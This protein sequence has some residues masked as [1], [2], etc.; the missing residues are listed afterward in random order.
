M[1]LPVGTRLYEAGLQNDN[2]GQ[3]LAVANADTSAVLLNNT[4]VQGLVNL[5]THAFSGY[6]LKVGTD[7]PAAT[8]SNFVANDN[9]GSL[10]ALLNADTSATKLNNTKV[11]GLAN[12]GANVFSAYP[13]VVGVDLPSANESRYVANDGT[14]NLMTIL[15]N[16]TSTVLLAN[17]K[18]TGLV[19]MGASAFSA[20]PLVVGTDMPRANESHFVA[21][22]NTGGLM[23]ILNADTSATKLNS[24]KLGGPLLD[25]LVAGT[26]VTITG[27]PGS[28]TGSPTISATGTSH[29]VASADAY[30]LTTTT[31]TAVMSY[32][33]PA[34]GQ[35]DVEVSVEVATAATIVTLVLS[36]YD[37]TAGA[38][39]TYDL[40]PSGGV[41]LAPGTWLFPLFG[42]LWAGTT[43]AI[44]V[45]ATAST[46]NQVYVSGRIKQAI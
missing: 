33:P 9:T 35:Y 38:I 12:L 8:E 30:E 5:G 2:S 44:A 40:T 42:A 39:E 13:L 19:H 3:I 11:Q 45:T 18:V 25:G 17:T 15:N 21:N 6:P 23:A 41:S 16:D 14:G 46:A 43:D 10:M 28:G 22:D 20:Y 32:T 29:T 34:D 31:A 26:G 4:K 24:A 1:L 27:L 37:A 7:M 36:W